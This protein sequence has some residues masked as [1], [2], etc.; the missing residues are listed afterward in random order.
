[1]ER[2]RVCAFLVYLLC[3]ISYSL[4]FR[5]SY[6]VSSLSAYHVVSVLNSINGL[7]TVNK[8]FNFKE[9]SDSNLKSFCF[10]RGFLAVC[11]IRLSSG[12]GTFYKRA[13]NVWWSKWLYLQIIANLHLQYGDD[14]RQCCRDGV[15]CVSIS[16]K[17]ACHI[18]F[19][20]AFHSIRLYRFAIILEG[21][22]SRYPRANIQITKTNAISCARSK[23]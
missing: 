7:W 9:T 15:W 18:K 11:I 20:C 19:R 21:R 17:A 13:P 6:V 4:S 3:F 8:H 14:A 1:M 23:L 16:D 22:R 12:R 5:Q 2:E 10:Q